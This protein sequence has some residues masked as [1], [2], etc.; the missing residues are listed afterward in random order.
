MSVLKGEG[1]VPILF[2]TTSVHAGPLT[3]TGYLARP[4]LTGEWPT[5]LLLSDAWGLT[6]SMKDI[7][8]RLARPGLAVLAPD[9][10]SGASPDRSLPAEEAEAAY[11][12]LDSGRVGAMVGDIRAFIT[13]PAGFWSSA[14]RGFGL[15]GIGHGGR[16]AVEAGAEGIGDALGLVA[17]PVA[18]VAGAI[19][20]VDQPL[21]AL[22]GRADD[23]APVDDILA[24][25]ESVPHGEFVLYEGLGGGFLDDFADGYDFSA[26]GDAIERLTNFFEKELPLAPA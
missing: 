13:N 12:E 24:M 18:G 3:H 22:Y 7:A 23:A 19:G 6:A 20:G 25:R 10:Y 26:A 4:D 15:L 2:G 21:L 1:K 9:V 11:A 5:V 14:E 8:R 17:A 16:F